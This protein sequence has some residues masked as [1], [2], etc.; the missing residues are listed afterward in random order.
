MGNLISYNTNNK[1]KNKYGSSRRIYVHPQYDK[2]KFIRNIEYLAEH[3]VKPTLTQQMSNPTTIGKFNQKP[4]TPFEDKRKDLPT[5]KIKSHH[6]NISAIE[7]NKLKNDINTLR[8]LLR[9]ETDQKSALVEQVKKQQLDML[10]NIKYYQ[11]LNVELQ[12]QINKLKKQLTSKPTESTECKKKIKDLT[13]QLEIV[14]TKLQ[15]KLNEVTNSTYNNMLNLKQLEI[16][17]NKERILVLENKQLSYIIQKIN[18][19]ESVPDIKGAILCKDAKDKLFYVSDLKCPPD[20]VD[21]VKQTTNLQQFY[22]DKLSKQLNKSTSANISTITSPTK[23][24]KNIETFFSF[25]TAWKKVEKLEKRNKELLAQI[26]HYLHIDK[27][28]ICPDCCNTSISDTTNKTNNNSKKCKLCDKCS[29]INHCRNKF[30]KI[31]GIIGG[32]CPDDYY[33]VKKYPEPFNNSNNVKT[34]FNIVLYLVIIILTYLFFKL[35]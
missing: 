4:N 11:A 8:Q 31:I 17:R 25:F 6:L 15:I 33:D 2:I 21:A 34:N 12:N 22:S 28:I 16:L 5:P 20:M 32:N 18:I 10:D 23:S 24:K 1:K 26:K 35:K 3:L 9:I 7:L 19:V 27:T 29:I 14:Q 13:E 30:N